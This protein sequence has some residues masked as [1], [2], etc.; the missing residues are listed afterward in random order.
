[1]RDSGSSA[2]WTPRLDLVDA[3]LQGFLALVEPV[4]VVAFAGEFPVQLTELDVP[5]HRHPVPDVVGQ[6]LQP[7]AEAPVIQQL[8]LV[9]QELF[10]LVLQQHLG[11]IRP[12][13]GHG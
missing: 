11:N 5:A 12:N 13:G 7:L 4:D 1:M 6:Q 2:Q 8:R 9:I 10:H 3:P